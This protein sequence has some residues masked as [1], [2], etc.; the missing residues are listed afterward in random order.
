MIYPT[1]PVK[2]MTHNHAVTVFA[3]CPRDLC[4]L[5]APAVVKCVP[6]APSSPTPGGVIY[7]LTL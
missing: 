6:V 4:L 7:M 5:T 3:D 2:I 1:Q